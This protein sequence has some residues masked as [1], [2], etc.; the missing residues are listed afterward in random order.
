DPQEVSALALLTKSYIDL[1]DTAKAIEVAQE[2]A[3]RE[4]KSARMQAFLGNILLAHGK[5][6]QARTA[7]NASLAADRSFEP[8]LLSLAQLD[9]VEGKWD[10]ARERL[11]AVLSMDRKSTTARLWMGVIE[12]ATGNFQPAL[13]YYREVLD[14]DPN[15]AEA[16]NNAAYLLADRTNQPDEAL[17]YAQ[18]AVELH[19]GKTAYE[20]T[21]GW[22]LYRKGLYSIAVPHL[23]QAASQKGSAVPKYHLA[24]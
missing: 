9:V 10:A 8:A 17:K 13:K 20:D 3:G 19:P 12:E 18:R 23:E 2:Y 5:L 4:P 14:S 6:S 16:L 15:N 7:L 11:N 24:M 22:A 1:K 21:L